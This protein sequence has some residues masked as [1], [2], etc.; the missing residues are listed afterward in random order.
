MVSRP[1]ASAL[2]VGRWHSGAPVSRTPD[3]D[4]TA[5]AADGLSNN[6]FLFTRI[7]RLE[8][9]RGSGATPGTFPRAIWKGPTVQSALTLRTSSKVNPRDQATDVGSE[10]DTLTRR[11]L[12]R[13]I[14][15]GTSPSRSPPRVT[16][17]FR[18]P[19]AAIS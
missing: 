9:V 1:S 7:R 11:I 5:L 2:L 14:P 16:T 12:R 19:W 4:S 3:M 17:A 8:F 6:D 10:F 13:G 15:F 18:A